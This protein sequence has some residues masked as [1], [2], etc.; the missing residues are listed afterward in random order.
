MNKTQIIK[1]IQELISE[2]QAQDIYTNQPSEFDR[3]YDVAMQGFLSA[4][5]EL[6][7]NARRKDE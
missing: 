7:H 3:G 6:L 4:L 2:V 5:E 1:S